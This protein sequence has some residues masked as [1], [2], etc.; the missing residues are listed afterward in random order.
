MGGALRMLE[1][2]TSLRGSDSSNAASR[3]RFKKEKVGLRA[4]AGGGEMRGGGD[5][6]G[7][8]VASSFDSC[9][10]MVEFLRDGL[11]EFATDAARIALASTSFPSSSVTVLG[12]TRRRLIVWRSSPSQTRR[13]FL[14]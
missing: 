4:L 9:E 7:V 6:G 10:K 13:T 14:E 11:D 5:D 12:S 3:F 2:I 1:L 8:T